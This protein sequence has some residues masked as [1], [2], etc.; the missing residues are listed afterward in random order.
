MEKFFCDNTLGKLARKLRLLGFDVK[1]W[2]G[3]TEEGRIL[4]T[5]S[6]KRWES[7]EG[8]SFLLF[9]DVWREQLKELERRYAISSKAKPF[10]RCAECNSVLL[11]TT[12]EEVKDKIPERVYLSATNFKFCPNCG[13]VYWSGTHVENIEREF[14]EIFK[15]SGKLDR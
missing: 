5:R 12:A 11:T 4:L 13:K 7:Y 1:F 10:S 3:E 15:R 9:A 8:E 2:N 6:R 14:A